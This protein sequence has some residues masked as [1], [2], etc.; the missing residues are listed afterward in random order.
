MLTI[1][2]DAVVALG[3]AID[4]A[5]HRGDMGEE[6]RLASLQGASLNRWLAAHG[7]PPLLQAAR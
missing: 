5:R 2:A 1:T 7:Y 6:S 4:A 3:K